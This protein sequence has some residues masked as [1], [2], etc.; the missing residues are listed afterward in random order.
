V[1]P[2]DAMTRTSWDQ[3][4][5]RAEGLAQRYHFAAD[6]LRFYQ[7]LAGFQKTI[8]ASW[9]LP[10]GAPAANRAAGV[11][12]DLPDLTL[13]LPKFSTLLC[14]AQKAGPAALAQFAAELGQ[15]GEEQRGNLLV[16][17]WKAD[18]GS[19]TGFHLG[20]TFFARALLQPYAEHL[21]EQNPTEG[22]DSE[23]STCPLCRR[24]PVVA[25]L[26]PEGDGGK[27]SLV[28]SL[29]ATEWAYRRIVCPACGEEN[30]DKLSVYTARE[31]EHLRIEACETCKTY[32]KAVD[33]TKD[34]FAV[35]VV[36]ELATTPLDL[37]AQGQGYRKLQLNVLGM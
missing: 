37:W 33:L 26:R 36:D 8:Y 16:T 23:R 10:G 27:R 3:R 5:A 12:T 32:L 15:E 9:K 25:V 7:E 24:R 11:L 1:A 29:C 6:V 14:V 19:E 31:F 22:V 2:L 30:P 17:Y 13:L 20:R 34:G 21:A 28:C 4:I 35:P 18:N